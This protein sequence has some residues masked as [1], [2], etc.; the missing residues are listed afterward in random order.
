[1]RSASAG[2]VSKYM[3]VDPGRYSIVS[4]EQQLL[5]E[6]RAAKLPQSMESYSFAVNC[7]LVGFGCEGYYE[8]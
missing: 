6:K 2:L 5:A 7:S 4:I 1:M 3:A 8:I